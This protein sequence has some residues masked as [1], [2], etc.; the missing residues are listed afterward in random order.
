[1]DDAMGLRW[2][3]TLVLGGI[4][5]WFLVRAA[6]PEATGPAPGTGER[7][8]HVAHALMA[9]AMIVMMWSPGAMGSM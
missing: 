4:G 9:V 6:R 8:T 5:C 3:V 1:M 7:L 2:I